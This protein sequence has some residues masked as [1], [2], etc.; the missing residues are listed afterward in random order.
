M[1]SDS[2]FALVNSRFVRLATTVGRTG[3][4]GN[5]IIGDLG[6]ICGLLPRDG[7]PS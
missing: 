2:F 1:D 7:R 5:G 4:G 3:L 6:R